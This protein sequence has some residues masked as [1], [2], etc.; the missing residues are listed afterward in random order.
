LAGTEKKESINFK[1]KNSD[2][3]HRIPL[4]INHTLLIIKMSLTYVITGAS[5]GLG[6]E[7]VKQISAKGHTVFALAR[8]PEACEGLKSLVD[9]KKV[10]AIKIDANS[11]ESA[12]VKLIHQIYARIFANVF[13]FLS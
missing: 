8:N 9:N 6:L 5:R 13:F 4:I 1:S 11:E 7:F 3:F 10:F 12:K 2:L